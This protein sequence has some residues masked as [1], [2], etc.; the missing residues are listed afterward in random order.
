MNVNPRVNLYQKMKMVNMKATST[1]YKLSLIRSIL[2]HSYESSYSTVIKS[3]SMKSFKF[4]SVHHNSEY[5][6][7][8]AGKLGSC[9]NSEQWRVDPASIGGRIGQRPCG[10]SL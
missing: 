6:G 9:I 1:S 7:W 5:Q 10:I 2:I 3:M 8:A 4:N